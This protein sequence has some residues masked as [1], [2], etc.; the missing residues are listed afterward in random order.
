MV[1]KELSDAFK[2][3]NYEFE[4]RINLIISINRN[5]ENSDNSKTNVDLIASK[6]SPYLIDKDNE[7][8]IKNQSNKFSSFIK[9]FFS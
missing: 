7:N 5:K 9:R 3:L 4:K 6:N 8:D 2:R 1:N